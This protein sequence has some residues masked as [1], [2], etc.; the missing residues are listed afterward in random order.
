MRNW[1][2]LHTR[3]PSRKLD[4][5]KKI[6]PFTVEKR[7]GSV[8]YKLRLL[9]S[10]KKIHPTFHIAL[11]EKKHTERRE[12]QPISNSKTPKKR[13]PNTRL[14]RSRTSKESAESLIIL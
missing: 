3:R 8:S 10:M 7:I 6:R 13:I 1:T 4:H 2:G 9:E 12:E 5:Q 14:K 11:L